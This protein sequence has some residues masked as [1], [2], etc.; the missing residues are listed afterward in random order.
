MVF[1]CL[2]FNV[3]TVLRFLSGKNSIL[4]SEIPGAG[5]AKVGLKLGITSAISVLKAPAK[6]AV[7]AVT[8]F[9]S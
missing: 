7:K 3:Y 9:A 4:I 1:L 2:L 6:I 8:E 5:F